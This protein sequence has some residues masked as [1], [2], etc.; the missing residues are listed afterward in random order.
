MESLSLT[1]NRLKSVKCNERI[2]AE[3]K[4]KRNGMKNTTNSSRN[5]SEPLV[6]PQEDQDLSLDLLWRASSPPL[7]D[8]LFEIDNYDSLRLDDDL[9]LG[10]VLDKIV[11]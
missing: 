5:N 6:N 8:N 10:C 2:D 7:F 9:S 1:K 11:S 3:A 4:E